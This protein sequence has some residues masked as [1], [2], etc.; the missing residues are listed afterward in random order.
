MGNAIT[1]YY[2]GDSATYWKGTMLSPGENK[3]ASEIKE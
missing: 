2:K 3:L 1:V